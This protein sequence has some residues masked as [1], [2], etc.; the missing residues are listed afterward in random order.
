[1]G[2]GTG[3]GNALAEAGGSGQSSQGISIQTF[4]ASLATAVVVFAV[5]FLLFL[6]IKGKLTRI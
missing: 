6:V 1:M 2:N 3:L 5:E 4:L